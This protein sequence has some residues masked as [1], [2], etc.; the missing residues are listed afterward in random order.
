MCT[1]TASRP[2]TTHNFCVCSFVSDST[3]SMTQFS[4]W[5]TKSADWNV[6]DFFS[7]DWKAFS[8]RVQHDSSISQAMV[9]S[10]V[11]K[12]SRNCSSG[13]C[14]SL[15]NACSA[16]NFQNR[17]SDVAQPAPFGSHRSFSKPFCTDCAIDD[18]IKST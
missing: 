10:R 3:F 6:P 17:S 14:R 2:D 13:Q 12:C 5:M 16:S 4:S 11:S 7:D 8:T 1:L 9:F 15:M 18:S